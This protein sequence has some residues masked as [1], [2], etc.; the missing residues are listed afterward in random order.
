[1]IVISSDD[2]E[3]ID[4]KRETVNQKKKNLSGNRSNR[5]KKKIHS[6][7][8]VLTAR[9]KVMI[10]NP[11]LQSHNKTFNPLT[12]FPVTLILTVGLWAGK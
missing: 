1:M 11:I 3:E 5:K 9:S 6:L 12:L 10:L 8:S 2:E 7:T 4:E